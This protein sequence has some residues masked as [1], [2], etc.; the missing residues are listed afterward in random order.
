VSKVRERLALNK[1]RSQRL[2]TER[3]NLKKL[4]K[5]EGLVLPE[6]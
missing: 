6:D 3:L 5:V 1:Q 2:Y 4:K